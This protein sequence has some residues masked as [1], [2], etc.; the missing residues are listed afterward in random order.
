MLGA[1]SLPSHIDPEHPALK[2]ES[3]TRTYAELRRRAMALA[4][5]LREKGAAPG[6]RIGAHLLNR[7][8]TFELYFACAY[9]GLTFVPVSWR[10]GP[11]EIGMTLSD[12]TPRVV[13]TQPAVV[14]AI[15]DPASELGIELIALEDDGSGEEYERI[16]SGAPIEP[17]F[18]RAEPHMI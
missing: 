2:W 13:F 17:P 16:A 9:A 10:L 8:E 5:S 12:C 15:R 11:R 6:D 3:E 1:D 14:D 4:R 7:G 18:E